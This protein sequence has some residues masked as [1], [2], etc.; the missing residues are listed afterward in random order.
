MM[1]SVTSLIKYE[2][3]LVERI[4]VFMRLERL[5]KRFFQACSEVSE[6]SHHSALLTLFEILE[7][8]ARSDIKSD[9]LQELDRQRQFFQQLSSRS[10][11]AEVVENSALE[12]ALAQIEEAYSNLL[13]TDGK[14]GA[15]LRD[16]SFLKALKSRASLPGSMFEFDLPVY[17]WWMRSN[18]CEARSVHLQEWGDRLLVVDQALETI[19]DHI[20]KSVTYSDCFAN[21][22]QFSTALA[23][24]QYQ[25]LTVEYDSTLNVYPEISANKF[26]LSLRFL[27]LLG[28]GETVQS[29]RTVTFKM[30]LCNL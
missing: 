3:P 23:G 2:F 24:R 29:E 27:E 13:Q 20:R 28:T 25:I 19:L 17:H 22:G 26:H 5:F 30:G 9:I 4:R 6:I 10:D 8:N 18:S 15:H 21:T 1:T 11:F 14:L 16:N 12:S 7:I